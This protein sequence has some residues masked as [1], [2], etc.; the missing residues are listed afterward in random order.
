MT[1]QTAYRGQ[2]LTAREAQVLTAIANGHTR[3][4]AGRELYLSA[5][6]IKTHLRRIFIKLG[7]R[8][9]AH[10]VA[11]AIATCQLPVDAITV[12]PTS[13]SSI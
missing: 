4:T 10:A 5:H 7:A 8:D 2:T 13:A 9:R 12:T 3:A 6:T 11:L 1:T